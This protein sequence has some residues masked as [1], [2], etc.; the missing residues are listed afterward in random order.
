MHGLYDIKNKGTYLFITES[1]CSLSPRF[2][3]SLD[4][5]L[6]PDIFMVTLYSMLNH[7]ALHVG[8]INQFCPHTCLPVILLEMHLRIR[9]SFIINSSSLTHIVLLLKQRSHSLTEW[10]RIFQGSLNIMKLQ[11][12]SM[13]TQVS[14]GFVNSGSKLT[15]C[16]TSVIQI[17]WNQPNNERKKMLIDVKPLPRSGKS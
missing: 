3:E 15:I 13:D 12:F 14:E 9:L 16:L 10:V 17:L 5:W 4:V 6:L 1:S 8:I 2:V 11:N 7:C